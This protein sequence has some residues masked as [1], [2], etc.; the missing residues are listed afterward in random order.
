MTSFLLACLSASSISSSAFSLARA[1]ASYVPTKM[2]V[3]LILLPVVTR[4]EQS[5]FYST[6]DYANGAGL[7]QRGHW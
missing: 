7:S 2:E 5:K 3:S 6:K 4:A 1:S